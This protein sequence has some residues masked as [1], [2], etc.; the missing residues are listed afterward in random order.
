MATEQQVRELAYAIWEKEG[1]PQGK[2]VEHYFRAR[3]IL[4]H[5]EATA[6]SDTPRATAATEPAP[7]VLPPPA[8]KRRGL[9]GRARGTGRGR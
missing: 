1:R 4:E 7:G 9:V 5:Q 2:D 8:E 6:V 3:Q